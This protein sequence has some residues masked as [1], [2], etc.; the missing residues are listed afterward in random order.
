MLSHGWPPGSHWSGP[1]GHTLCQAMTHGE[2]TASATV[3]GSQMY[4]PPSPVPGS[5]PR[6]RGHHQLSSS[7]RHSII[8]HHH[9][10]VIQSSVIIH[11]SVI[12]SSGYSCACTQ[13][14][15]QSSQPNHWAPPCPPRSPPLPGSAKNQGAS[16]TRPHMHTQH[17]PL[18]PQP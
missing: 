6:I 5:M 14:S 17:S 12:Q 16:V 3:M 11:Q 18:S 9:Q 8:S 10:S 7:V 1:H 15:L 2:S 13:H 4:A